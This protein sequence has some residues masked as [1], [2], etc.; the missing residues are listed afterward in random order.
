MTTVRQSIQDSVL[1]QTRARRPLVATLLLTAMV[2]LVTF[3]MLARQAG[4]S[5]LVV[6]GAQ[7][8]DADSILA[9]VGNELD[10]GL[11]S[12]S[13]IAIETALESLPWIAKADVSR[14]FPGTVVATIEE[15]QP[16]AR[17]GDDRLVSDRGVV[18]I[19]NATNTGNAG[20]GDP[21]VDV[22]A[23]PQLSGPDASVVEVLSTYQILAPAFADLGERLAALEID[24]RGAWTARLQNG[25]EIRLG[26]HEV[27]TR[28]ARFVGPALTA[29]AA[30]WSRVAYVDLRYSNGFAVGWRE[31]VTANPAAG[32]A[33]PD[34]NSTPAGQAG[35]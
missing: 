33:T 27:E 4:P 26:R 22:M 2:A 18:F 8:T 10:A 24:E 7:T 17:W 6:H 9:A 3:G 28:V 34:S 25:V 16:L 19:G 30:E 1:E 21:D 23:L 14:R 20:K 12:V 5:R 32:Q 35:D 29:L 11:F 15:H 13:L 31:D